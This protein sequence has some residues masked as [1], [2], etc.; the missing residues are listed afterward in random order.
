MVNNDNQLNIDIFEKIDSINQQYLDRLDT[1][2]E[3]VYKAISELNVAT[4]KLKTLESELLSQKKHVYLNW[5]KTLGFIISPTI[6]ISAFVF[7][8]KYAPCGQ[9]YEFGGVKLT[10]S[11][12]K[13]L[14][15]Q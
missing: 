15:A 6:L 7:L 3:K 8:S 10:T 12:C 2:N 1:N 4:N 9:T 14:V 13:T 11:A 5:L